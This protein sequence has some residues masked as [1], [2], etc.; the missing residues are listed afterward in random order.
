MRQT[1]IYLLLAA[2]LLGACTSPT[3]YY[4]AK[5]GLAVSDAMR[6]QT[7]NPD[8]SRNTDP[9][10]GLD[11]VSARESVGRYQDSFKAPER[12]FEIFSGAR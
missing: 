9:V 8:A 4:D 5:Y 3:P 6:K 10:A 12:T 2:A 1:T 7:L 11:G